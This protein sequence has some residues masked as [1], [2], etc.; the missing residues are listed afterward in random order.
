MS[1]SMYRVRWAERRPASA[2][3]TEKNAQGRAVFGREKVPFQASFIYGG[4]SRYCVD[5]DEKK[6]IKKKRAKLL[7]RPCRDHQ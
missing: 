4:S 2:S 5:V 3:G 6:E 7:V 1:C